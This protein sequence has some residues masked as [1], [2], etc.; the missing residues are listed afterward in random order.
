MA[1]IKKITSD[2]TED[3]QENPQTKDAEAT[4]GKEEILPTHSLPTARF[5]EGKDVFV[6]LRDWLLVVLGEQV[7]ENLRALMGYEKPYQEDETPED[8]PTWTLNLL[9]T[10]LRHN[11]QTSDVEH[12]ARTLFAQWFAPQD[13]NKRLKTEV[14]RLAEALQQA[15]EKTENWQKKCD[16]AQMQAFRAEENLKE[17]VPLHDFVDAVFS[18]KEGQ[19]FLPL[20]EDALKNPAENLP[21]FALACGK[22]WSAFRQEMTRLPESEEEKM[23]V[24]HKQL[25]V[26]LKGISGQ[27]I[28][29]RRQILDLVGKIASTCLQEHDFISPEE[30][31]QINLDMHTPIGN[32]ELI[33][34][35]ISFAIIRREGRQVM[36]YAEVRT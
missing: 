6:Q 17:T 19:R 35:G 15:Q 2:S 20:W 34:E 14:K 5:E 27:H 8:L 30:S 23:E 13:E 16:T 26:F 3:R 28:S 11:E 24:L 22:A 25:S 18:D 36:R 10:G 1:L 9:K 21:E 7:W 31:R 29:Q 32:G 4:V 33:R 12:L